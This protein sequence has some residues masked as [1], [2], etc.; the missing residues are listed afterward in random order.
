MVARVLGKVATLFPMPTLLPNFSDY[1]L[2]DE[3]LLC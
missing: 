2:D 3:L 1:K